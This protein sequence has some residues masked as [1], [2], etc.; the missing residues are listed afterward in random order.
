[1]SIG[2]NDYKAW[3]DEAMVASNTAGYVGM[4]AAQTITTMAQR[5][6]ELE[7]HKA[8]LEISLEGERKAKAVLQRL[9]DDRDARISEI[10][11]WIVCA[12]IASPDDLLQSAEY[13]TRL[14]DPESLAKP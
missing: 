4:S 1:M 11:G 13:F 2:F 10:H 9:L 14:T 7:A 6:E 5:I 12:V 8:A 3:Y